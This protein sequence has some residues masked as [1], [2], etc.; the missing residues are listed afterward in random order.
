M[1]S[2]LDLWREAMARQ[3]ALRREAARD[4]LA[5][6]VPKPRRPA[7]RAALARRLRE[8]VNWTQGRAYPRSAASWK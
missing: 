6:S 4:R 8:L 7:R 2:D 3:H 1:Y 5:A